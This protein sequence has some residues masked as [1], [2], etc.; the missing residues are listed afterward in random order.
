MAA[1]GGL[2]V[3]AGPLLGS[4]Y[5]I[6]VPQ[7]VHLDNV[8]VA[9]T[10]FGWLLLLLQRPGGLAQAAA[11]WRD[12]I[13][14]FLARRAGLDPVAARAERPSAGGGDLSAGLTLR[15][16]GPRPA[17]TV[18]VAEGLTKR[19]GGLLAV[20][21]VSLEVRAGEILGMIGPNG[22]GKTTLFELLGGFTAV[23]SGRIR[24]GGEDITG[25]APE[26]RAQRGLIRSFQDAA[27][28]P[29]LTVHES[30]MLAFERS[31]PTQVV[32]T[33]LGWTGPDRRKSAAADELL[34]TVGLGGYRDTQI[35]ALSTGTRRITELACLIALEPTILLLDEP[36]SG[37]AQ[38]ETEALGELLRQV[39]AALDLTMVV[40]E[41]DIPLIMS[42]ADRI[43]AMESGAVLMVGTPSEVQAD[44]RVIASYLGTDTRALERSAR[45][46]VQAVRA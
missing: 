10:S 31:A 23:D 41:H 21:G 16:P 28:F 33:L 3:L 40:I 1:V 46:T 43:V 35:N 25:M 37:I 44:T 19:F 5:I 34:A 13:T 11:G 9:A 36:T 22:A 18:L 4:L 17:G 45:R 26:R 14:D 42:L 6:G 2:G 39:R 7:F 38:R 29:T 30:V 20:N 32:P 27:L 24:F 12:A 15:T 8:G